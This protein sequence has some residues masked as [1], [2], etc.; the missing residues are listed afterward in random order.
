MQNIK[1]TMYN[2]S[3]TNIQMYGGVEISAFAAAPTSENLGLCGL[4][5]A[6]DANPMYLYQPRFTKAEVFQST[7]WPCYNNEISLILKS[8]VPLCAKGCMS[9]IT[10][11]EFVGMQA[12]SGPLDLRPVIET[13][14]QHLTFSDNPRGKAGRAL[15]SNETKVLTLYLTCCM[16]CNKEYK[17]KFTLRNPG[18]PQLGNQ[19]I[20]EATNSENLN[21]IAKTTVMWQ[22]T[23]FAPMFIHTANFS[24]T[25]IKFSTNIPCGD[26]NV[27][28]IL[29][30]DVAVHK[31]TSHDA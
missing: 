3:V 14:D 12:E 8:N 16:E 25:S 6:S 20:V 30:M 1:S 4:V 11:S 5:N 29:A 18:C 19:L 31:G 13:S 27:D 9:Q 28:V 7:F 26:N 2:Y 10:I 21:A 15:W 24:W 23:S 17:F 22:N